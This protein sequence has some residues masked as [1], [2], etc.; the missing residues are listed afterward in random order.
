MNSQHGDDVDDYVLTITIF[1]IADVFHVEKHGDVWLH[2]VHLHLWVHG[3]GSKQSMFYLH[4]IYTVFL[5]FLFVFV[6]HVLQNRKYAIFKEKG[7]HYRLIILALIYRS[8]FLY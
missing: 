5:Y 7:Q 8:V 4:L 2:Q 6:S 3:H 1:V